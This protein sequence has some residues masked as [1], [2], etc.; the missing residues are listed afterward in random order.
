MSVLQPLCNK[1]TIY[2]VTTMLATSKNTLFPGLNHLQ[3]A[4]TDDPL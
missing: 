2:Q 1:A 4:G 3:T